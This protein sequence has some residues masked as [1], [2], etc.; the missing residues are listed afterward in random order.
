MQRQ[1]AKFRCSTAVHHSRAKHTTYLRS[2]GSPP[3]STGGCLHGPRKEACLHEKRCAYQEIQG[4]GP[5]NQTRTKCRL[6]GVAGAP[7]PRPAE[8]QIPRKSREIMLAETFR[9]FFFPGVCVDMLLPCEGESISDFAWLISTRFP[10]AHLNIPSGEQRSNRISLSPD[11]GETKRGHS[12]LRKATDTSTSPRKSCI[13][14]LC[15]S[16]RGSNPPP[17]D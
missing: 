8:R 3:T 15:C 9:Y 7:T 10:N 6:E 16:L 14:P 5:A 17:I 13:L 4:L 11:K 12:Y 1:R 2:M